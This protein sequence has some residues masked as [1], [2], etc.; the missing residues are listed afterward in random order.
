MRTPDWRPRLA[1]LGI[2]PSGEPMPLAGGD[3]AA[4]WRLETHQGAVVIK[5][6]DP[7]RLAGEADGLAALRCA[8]PA[9][10]WWCPRCWAAMTTCW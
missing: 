9:R 10:P 8:A 3:I 5:R 2:E 7:A 1:A 4:V 6:D